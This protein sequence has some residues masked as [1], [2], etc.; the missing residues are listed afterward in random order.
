M[1]T[2][3]LSKISSSVD[4]KSDLDL[5]ELNSV[6]KIIA[7]MNQSGVVY[8]ES[9]ILMY[10]EFVN[11]IGSK[12]G[13]IFELAS[14]GILENKIL[15][16]NKLTLQ[17]VY[18]VELKN[19]KFK[20]ASLFSKEN[21]ILTFVSVAKSD[22]DK[23]FE[24]KKE[25]LKLSRKGVVFI[26]ETPIVI[27]DDFDK[28]N[29]IN[30]KLVQE[31]ADTIN[32]FFSM[33]S[34]YK[35][36]KIPYIQTMILNGP[37]GSGKCTFFKSLSREVNEKIIV[38][39]SDT[40]NESFVS[41]ITTAEK[42]KSL[43]YF[44]YMDTWVSEVDPALIRDVFES[45][46]PPEGLFIIISA[47]DD[48]VIPKCLTSRKTNSKPIKFERPNENDIKEY[49]KEFNFDEKNLKAMV[50]DICQNQLVWNDLT[51]F[52]NDLKLEKIKVGDSNK[53]LDNSAKKIL[54]VVIKDK[55]SQDVKIDIKKYFE[56]KSE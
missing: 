34:F 28:E 36:N 39:S 46:S 1:D 42:S 37:F 31:A 5:S 44:E 30:G 21:E 41:A 12:K 48:S 3:F 29:L 38:C 26:G 35:T 14:Q 4:Y 6:Q 50:K 10:D 32:N 33:G 15:N 40:T 45:M 54:E 16:K 53:K 23:Y 19:L 20:F 55:L 43:L 7:Y 24:F 8:P 18:W 22:L 25:F 9:D 52:R 11:F 13:E 49:L 2:K 56:G 17:G 47:E 27:S 51:I